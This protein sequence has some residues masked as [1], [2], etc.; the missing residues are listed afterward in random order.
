[1]K[2]VRR[3]PALLSTAPRSA[4]QVS[5]LESAVAAGLSEGPD[6]VAFFED[7]AA[8]LLKRPD[9]KVAVLFRPPQDS[10]A[11]LIAERFPDSDVTGY[12]VTVSESE[13]HVQ[14]ATDG[15]FDIIVDDSREGRDRA[16][17]LRR[18]F[19]HVG[20]GGVLLMRQ[21][22][23]GGL[24]P[25]S[26][27]EERISA[28]LAGVLEL[29]LSAA[30]TKKKGRRKKR[31]DERQL[32][33][34]VDTLTSRRNHIV[35]THGRRVQAKLR[36]E[37]TNSWL[38][39]RGETAGRVLAV[40][41]AL[42]FESRAKVR[43][44]D[45]IRAGRFPTSYDV[46]A[47][48]LRVYRNVLCTPGQVVTQGNVML[49][50]TFRH[51]QRPRLGNRYAED[52]GVR[53][54]RPLN[55]TKRPESLRGAYFYLDSEFRGHFGHALTEQLSRLWAWRQAKAEFPDLK[56]ILALNKNRELAPFEVDLYAAAGI[57][58]EDLVFVRDAVRVERL[59]AA[60]PMLSQPQYV[61][62]DLR[63]T[64]CEVSDALASH[65]P[66]R[67]Y[68]ERFFCARR[69]EKR[70]CR[71]AE[72]VEQYFARHGFDVVFPED[73]PLA[74][75]ARMFRSADVVA[76]FAGSALFN[77][78][79]SASPKRGIVISSESYTAQNEYMVSAVV[80]HEL[81]VAWCEAE[82]PKP[83]NRW[84]A[85]AFHSPFTFDFEREGLFVDEVLRDL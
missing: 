33:S 12:D 77:L 58:P 50:D 9:A 38:T 71:N 51:N 13:L 37:E 63:E 17:L 47:I 72:E 40:R 45:S 7:L 66:D 75:Q 61:H 8:E 3:R 85:R 80:G 6:N 29:R 11:R 59:V 39:A 4:L 16:A 81:S 22:R 18:V 34:A 42:A 62:P 35:L 27:G 10:L 56:A 76:G 25:G 73:Y 15:W 78:C 36:D 49:P 74:E 70:A 82:I 48:S 26:Y 46:P 79:L 69:T 84:S 14:L 41:P 43:E 83:E 68:P 24:K 54:A 53:F 2:L 31:S 60:T 5:L 20:R 44:N 1:M 30:G 65:A 21:A 23:S 52:Y 67:D 32:A 64:W 55:R 19:F 57:A 28:L